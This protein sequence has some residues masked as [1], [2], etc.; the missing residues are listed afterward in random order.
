MRNQLLR[1]ADWA[2]L[3]HGVEIRTPLVDVGLFRALAPLLAG[4][5]PPGKRD[6]AAVAIPALPEEI[7][8]RPKTGFGTPVQT[9]AQDPDITGTLR[10]GL[11][12]WSM[13]V[14]GLRK[15]D[16]GLS[17]GQG[18]RRILVLITDAFGGHGGISQF[19]QDLLSALC[20][21]PDT[22][23]VV[24]I[25]RLLP[26]PPGPLPSR[27]RQVV[28][29]LGHKT[30]YLFATLREVWGNPNFDL[31]ICG[32]INLLPLAWFLRNWCRAPLALVIHGVDAWT[33]TRNPMANL[34]ARSP[35][36][37]LP[38]SLITAQRFQAWS[39]VESGRLHLLQNAVHLDHYAFAPKPAYLLERYGLEQHP[40][41]MTLGRMASLERYKGFDEVLEALPALIREYPNLRYLAIGDGSDHDRLVAK[42][43]AMGLHEHVIFPGLIPESE[44]AD[45]Y[46]LADAYVMPSRGEGFGRVFLEAMACGVPVVASNVDG[47]REAV[48][49]GRLGQMVD[50]ADPED[51]LRGI[52]AALAAP[53]GI[54]EGLDYFAFPR[55]VERFHV[56]LNDLCQTGG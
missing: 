42:T 9:W 33:P 55:F 36:A 49:E 26:K 23:E 14:A 19:N 16:P 54:P 38:V 10:R 15:G 50:P 39:K 34:L 25:P 29:G 8:N 53:H 13:R 24:A 43:K 21:H 46:R 6:L 28:T 41:I 56:L 37:I 12:P 1:D 52:R 27:L 2:G 47:S 5:R 32:H 18:R 4:P 3:G 30:S 22:D 20:N 11:R 48:M 40:V 44:K 31:I 45:H 17:E 7:L 35:D 51:I